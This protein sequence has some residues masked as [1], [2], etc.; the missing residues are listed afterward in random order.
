MSEL[1]APPPSTQ[2]LTTPI[3]PPPPPPA[4]GARLF[5]RQSTG[6][7][8]VWVPGDSE[9]ARAML[10]EITGAVVTGDFNLVSGEL[11]ELLGDLQR[12]TLESG[13]ALEALAPAGWVYVGSVWGSEACVQLFGRDE[14]AIRAV[15]VT[16][17]EVMAA[18]NHPPAAGEQGPVPPIVEVELPW[19]DAEENIPG[20]QPSSLASAMENPADYAALPP[21]PGFDHLPSMMTPTQDS[22]DDLPTVELPWL[23]AEEGIPGAAPSRAAVLIAQ[24]FAVIRHARVTVD[25]DDGFTVLTGKCDLINPADKH[26]S[27]WLTDLLTH[28]EPTPAS[29]KVILELVDCDNAHWERPGEHEDM[30]FGDRDGVL[31]IGEAKLYVGAE[32]AWFGEALCQ[33]ANLSPEDSDDGGPVKPHADDAGMLVEADPVE[34]CCELL[35]EVLDDAHFTSGSVSI[36]DEPTHSNVTIGRLLF[37]IYAA[38]DFPGGSARAARVLGALGEALESRHADRYPP[39]GHGSSVQCAACASEE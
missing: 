28:L 16:L 18:G 25:P 23:D 34:V 15:A 17:A 14:R 24:A 37:T 13:N 7:G 31:I 32:F 22:G 38:D 30:Q 3:T 11:V 5:T 20:A 35:A 8:D 36:D 27:D 6:Y 39:C 9:Q 12:I 2:P 33:L 1:E 26:S 19:Q 4:I 29:E 21:L 10:V